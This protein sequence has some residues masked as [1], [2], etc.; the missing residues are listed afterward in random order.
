MI[1]AVILGVLI[2]ALV[3]YLVRDVSTRTATLVGYPG[4]L[5]MNMLKMLI[6]P[7]IVSTLISG[8]YCGYNHMIFFFGIDR[9]LPCP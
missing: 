2:G 1:L 5:L 6:I 7:L 3:K 8:K 9:E 4:E